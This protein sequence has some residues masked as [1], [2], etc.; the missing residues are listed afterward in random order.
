LIKINFPLYFR[1]ID[2][3]CSDQGLKRKVSASSAAQPSCCNDFSN[4]SGGF[5]IERVDSF[6]VT[7]RHLDGRFTF[8]RVEIR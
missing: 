1:L 4:W 2:H 3:V 8:V 6:H 5:E 7:V